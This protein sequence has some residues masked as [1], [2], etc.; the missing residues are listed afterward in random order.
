MPTKKSPTFDTIDDIRRE[1]QAPRRTVTISVNEDQEVD[2]KL[3]GIGRRAFRELSE[4]HSDDTDDTGW[5]METFPP[6]LVAACS[7]SPKLTEQE[8][9]EIWADDEW[10]IKELDSLFH[11]AIALSSNLLAGR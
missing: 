1:K 8:A 9:L 6:A 3:R 11:A 7:E 2:W 10:T 5:N 4:A